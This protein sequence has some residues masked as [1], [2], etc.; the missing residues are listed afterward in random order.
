MAFR[1]THPTV[2]LAT[3][4]AHAGKNEPTEQTS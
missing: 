1:W 3:G 2:K 4:K